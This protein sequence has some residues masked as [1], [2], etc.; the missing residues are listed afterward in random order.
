MTSNELAQGA[1]AF[2]LTFILLWLVPPRESNWTKQASSHVSGKPNQPA[3][4]RPTASQSTNSTQW[5]PNTEK[6]AA[7]RQTAVQTFPGEQF[8]E[9]RLNLLSLREV[10]KWP[11]SSVQYAIN[12]MFARHGGDFPPSKASAKANF[13]R[14]SWYQP[15]LGVDLDVIEQEFSWVEKEN[16]KLLA[17]IRDGKPFSPASPPMAPYATP[18]PSTPY[19]D[20]QSNSP[21]DS[22]PASQPRSG[23]SLRQRHLQIRNY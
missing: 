22:T 9:T 1:G 3:S 12:E 6:T 18:Y 23:S 13:Q 8:P 4:L 11:I 2:V 15:R 14:Y 7:Q 10:S 19:T 17:G 5:R 16:L 21:A 20:I